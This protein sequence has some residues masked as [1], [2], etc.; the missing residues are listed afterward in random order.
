MKLIINKLSYDGEFYELYQSISK[1]NLIYTLSFHFSSP[2]TEKDFNFDDIIEDLKSVDNTITILNDNQRQ[3][4]K[5][6]K[7][8]KCLY[9]EGNNAL[10]FAIDI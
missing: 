2:H 7:L 3:T 6:V 1:Y 8:L 9:D 5:I 4:I 10:V